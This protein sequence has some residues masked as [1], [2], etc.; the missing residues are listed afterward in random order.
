MI[1][2]TLPL[3]V[4]WSVGALAAPASPLSR[5]AMPWTPLVVLAVIFAAS[6]VVFVALTRRWTSHRLWVALQDWAR[7]HDF[8]LHGL[9]DAQ[10]PPPV[11]ELTQFRPLARRVAT[12]DDK[13]W[14]AQVQTDTKRSQST[15]VT[16][17]AEPVTWHVII[18]RTNQSWRPSGL[19]PAGRER[20]LIDL[21]ALPTFP[22]L[23]GHER[24]VVCAGDLVD[25]RRLNRS[26]APG[27][28]PH[29]VG[30]L[31]KNNYLVIDFTSRPFDPIELGRMIAL[32][33]QLEKTLVS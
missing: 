14:L 18:R 15:D 13:T 16:P 24:F 3:I 28:L 6:T 32:V 5:P 30:L 10:V 31:L 26:H 11:S 1:H 23:G 8:E 19:R 17:P 27:L 12:K 4:G 25:A 33:D 7:Q 29:D 21:F 9:P 20:A 22:A 2:Q